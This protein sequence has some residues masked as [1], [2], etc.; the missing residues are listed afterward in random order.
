MGSGHLECLAQGIL[1]DDEL[2]S[3]VVFLRHLPPAASQGIPDMYTH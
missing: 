2:W 3:I 1:N